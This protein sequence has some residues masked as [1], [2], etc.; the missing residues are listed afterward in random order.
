MDVIFGGFVG[1]VP[2]VRFVPPP[3]AQLAPP[4]KTIFTRNLGALAR[5]H[6][7]LAIRLGTLAPRADIEFVQSDEG[8][9]A[10][11]GPTR[12][13]L[14]SLRRPVEE[15]SRLASTID[16]A[17][18]GCAVVVGIGLGHGLR[19]ALQRIAGRSLV[20]AFE[21]D[22]ALLRA[23]LERIDHS[24]WLAAPNLCILT[25]PDDAGAM[26]ESVRGW[27]GVL[28][29]GVKFVEAPVS[30]ARLGPDAARFRDRLATVIRAVRTT[31]VTTLMQAETTLRNQLMNVDRYAISAGIDDLADAA[32]GR[33]AIVVSAGPSLRRNVDLLRHEGITDHFVTIAAQTVLRP[34]LGRGIRPRFVTALD[35]HEI[36]RRF[37]EGLTA[38]VVAGITLV[39]EA[40]ANP[41]ILGSFPG[42]VRLPGDAVLDSILGPAFA[43]PMGS[44]RPGATVAHMAYYLARHLGCDPVILIGQDLGFTD[45]QYYA[46]GAAIHSVWASEL[47]EFNTLEMME[48]QRIVRHRSFLCRTNDHL[49]RPVYTDE[50]MNSYRVQFERDFRADAERGLRV[51]DATEGGVAKLHCEAMPL[52]D[53][54]ARFDPGSATP[55][56]EARPPVDAPR[57]L[58]ALRARTRDIRQGVFRVGKASRAAETI[59]TEM[60]EQQQDRDRVN[61]LIRRVDAL[62]DEVVREDPAFSLVQHINQT[63][64]LKR[65][66]ADR[67]MDLAGDLAPLERQK[68]QIERDTMNV[69]WLGDAADQLGKLLDSAIVALDGGPRLTR[70]VEEQ[71]DS[72]EGVARA[73]A[74]VAALIAVD[75]L[76]GGL[77]TP[78]DLAQPLHCGANALALTVRRLLACKEI[79]RVVLIAEDVANARSLLGALPTDA[80]VQIEY[81]DPG[82]IAARRAAVGIGRLWSSECWRGGLG[83]L[84]VFDEACVPAVMAP[85]VDRLGIDAALL[86][87]DD[88]ALLD[89]AIADDLVRRW[90]TTRGTRLTFAHAAPGLGAC[91][92]ERKLLGDM[93]DRAS[94]GVLAT[95]GSMLGYLPI[96]PASDPISRPACVTPAPAARD[97]PCRFI[98]DSPA[99]FEACR[100][101]LAEC[102]DNAGAEHIASRAASGAVRLERLPPRELVLE[103]CTG[104]A[105][106]GKRGRW[107]RGW[108]DSIERPVITRALA[109]R[110]LRQFAEHRPDAVL[111]LAGAGDPIHHPDL[112]GIVGLARRAGFAGVHVRTDL[113]CDADRLRALIDADPDVISIDL[114]AETPETY[115]AIMGADLFATV[116]AN[117]E[118]L[119]RW[120][121]ERPAPGGLPRP[122]IVPRIARCDTVYAEIE[123]F[124]D[125]WLLAAGAA[126]IDPMPR[127]VPGERIEPL[128]P[129]DA[130]A[131]RLKHSRVLVLS[132][133]RVPSDPAD[134]T[135]ERVVGDAS[136]EPLRDIIRRLGATEGAALD[137][138][139]RV[140]SPH[141][142]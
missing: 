21:P 32:R 76:R 105:T 119:V 13:A 41:A 1:P 26:S 59:L 9:S 125:R 90:R 113:A 28:G 29:I 60:A 131:Q 129:P 49:G 45:G 81:A 56:P 141:G 114:A 37:Y 46:A 127:A 10:R 33:P 116:R 106:S 137:R 86:V 88:W 79:E 130:A 140:A 92:I 48:W 17:A 68:R 43:R 112:A 103:L 65:F 122:W 84:T 139:S 109:D 4:T 8:L 110:V 134:L 39:A 104:R 124:F 20:L 126:V 12:T 117:I 6:P 128:A 70:D 94:A 3:S 95:I 73:S 74:R 85:V 30:A 18:T 5:R 75:P 98:P 23:V 7:A 64:T 97:A 115:R 96:A 40:K 53:A 93:A 83:G 66:K 19:A 63:G 118:S 99:R 120:R 58:V 35:Y 135:P 142:V 38:E 16:L 82:L 62:R 108:G 31:L 111:T 71:P 14:A 42:T 101:L 15:A 80:P 2:M 91:V 78:R 136:R 44:I 55:T 89:P 34:L 107:T 132:D 72:T 138:R 52:R 77:G 133:G 67:D 27:E 102:G 54:I 100:R 22:L 36:S 47:N 61:R 51:I 87:G 25:D 50:Q 121:T 123:P 69:R 11:L 57:R 24:A